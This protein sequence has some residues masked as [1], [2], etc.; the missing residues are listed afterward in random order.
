MKPIAGL[1]GE[2]IEQLKKLT[3]KP[4]YTC[5]YCGYEMDEEEAEST[6]DEGCPSCRHIIDWEESEYPRWPKDL[7]S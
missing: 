4:D 2:Q 5:P 7:K 1:F 3:V 6:C